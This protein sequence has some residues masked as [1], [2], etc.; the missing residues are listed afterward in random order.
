M[1]ARE[2][3]LRTGDLE[4]SIADLERSQMVATNDADDGFGDGLDG[5]D[6]PGQPAE[7]SKRATA[8]TVGPGGTGSQPFIETNTKTQTLTQTRPRMDGDDDNEGEEGGEHLPGTGT[9]ADEGRRI[10]S[11]S[12]GHGAQLALAANKGKRSDAGSPAGNTHAKSLAETEDEQSLWTTHEGSLHTT[13]TMKER[14][15]AIA[16]AAWEQAIKAEEMAKLEDMRIANLEGLRDISRVTSKVN[17][18][19]YLDGT[20]LFKHIG[21]PHPRHLHNLP[22]RSAYELYSSGGEPLYTQSYPAEDGLCGVQCTDFLFYSGTS[23]YA[24]HVLA[25]PE[26]SQLRGEN[27]REILAAADPMFLEPKPP[28]QK[29]F[30]REKRFVPKE[31]YGVKAASNSVV[32]AAKKDLLAFLKDSFNAFENENIQTS[33]KPSA[34][35]AGIWAPLVTRN[36]QRTMHWLPNDLFSSSHLALGAKISFL[37]GNLTTNWR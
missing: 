5:E 29:S 37:E 17:D 20:D 7:E 1:I 3:G 34:Y 25:I 32:Q 27:P 21:L 24:T 4:L 26:I 23:M 19:T 22:M 18:G 14:N 12:A 31:G 2:K 16:N 9:G 30:N 6:D 15:F 35:W 28:F 36:E 8:A 10:N 11:S 33:D 13:A